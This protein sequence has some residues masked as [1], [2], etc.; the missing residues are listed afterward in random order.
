V[1]ADSYSR[2][3]EDGTTVIFVHPMHR[4]VVEDLTRRSQ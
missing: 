3:V 2:A 1:T 4:E